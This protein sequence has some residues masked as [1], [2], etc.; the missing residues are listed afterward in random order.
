MTDSNSSKT[1]ISAIAEPVAKEFI[2]IW[3]KAS[4]PTVGLKTV[5]ARVIE[6]YECGR[7]C[8]WHDCEYSGRHTQFD[9]CACVCP[10]VEC[11][12]I[13]CN[14]EKCEEIHIK[15]A[16]RFPKKCL[17]RVDP[18]ELPFL[19]DQRGK[20]E[21]FI[22]GVHK[23]D[24]LVLQKREKRDNAQKAREERERKR[25]AEEKEKQDEANSFIFD[26]AELET[27]SKRKEQDPEF[28]DPDQVVKVRQRNT[29]K[30]DE[31]SLACDRTEVSS[32]K[33]SL[34]CNSYAKDM[35]WLTHENRLTCTLDRTKLER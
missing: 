14:V 1:A 3:K 27:V 10:Q 9:I 22:G 23:K 28:P 32:R 12:A 11:D 4:I 16:N 34:I 30:L 7:L 6:A 18:K 31:T 33:A 2:E 15:H 24:T 35:G 8:E 21:M 5:T 26:E 19:M 17:A 25:I 20:R 29:Y 13:G